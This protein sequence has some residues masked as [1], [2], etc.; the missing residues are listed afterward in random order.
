MGRDNEY[1]QLISMDS[2]IMVEVKTAYREGGYWS[3]FRTDPTTS[4]RAEMRLRD[5]E[6]IETL[7]RLKGVK[8]NE[9]IGKIWFWESISDNE[10]K[11]TT[12]YL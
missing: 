11:L 4:R 7:M 5:L 2:P 10:A 9:Q 3:D 8:K 6:A 1:T 12:I